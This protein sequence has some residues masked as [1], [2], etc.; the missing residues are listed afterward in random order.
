MSTSWSARAVLSV[1]LLSFGCT[2]NITDAPSQGASD[3]LLSAS[4]SAPHLVVAAV[5]ATMRTSGTLSSGDI[6]GLTLD[7]NI[8]IEYRDR[9]EGLVVRYNLSDPVAPSAPDFPGTTHVAAVEF[10][11]LGTVA[12]DRD[13]RR[14]VLPMLNQGGDHHAPERHV[15][16]PDRPSSG[17]ADSGRL[18]QLV[19]RL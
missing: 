16:I 13:G 8:G 14:M 7:T 17:M 19:V 18:D 5:S 11:P 9:P 15:A 6:A 3:H 12:W 10:G 2:D 4:A 1:I